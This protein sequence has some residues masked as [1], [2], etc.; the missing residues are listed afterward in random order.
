MINN[1]NNKYK[2]SICFNNIYRQVLMSCKAV[3]CL[4]TD[5]SLNSKV[6]DWTWADYCRKSNLEA[7]DF[8]RTHCRCSDS[9]K[10]PMF[11]ETHFDFD[12]SHWS[13]YCTDASSPE[14]CC[15]FDNNNCT[16]CSSRDTPFAARIS[17]WAAVRRLFRAADESFC[18][19]WWLFVWV[20][21]VVEL[22]AP[23][24]LL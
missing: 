14:T 19:V 6:P 13:R 23:R 10:A 17:L 18:L 3:A 4:D 8:V 2:N 7:F 24:G 12:N 1:N 5:L 15:H 20:E 21:L 16:A 9:C 22:E 11:R